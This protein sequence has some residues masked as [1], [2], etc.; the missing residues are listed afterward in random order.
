MCATCA[1][2]VLIDPL[3]KVTSSSMVDGMLGYCH[4]FPSYRHHLQALGTRM[5]IKAWSDDYKEMLREQVQVAPGGA[6]RSPDVIKKPAA[7]Q[8]SVVL[9]TCLLVMIM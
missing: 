4:N 1:L 5:G 9:Q 3:R 8:V 2:Q 7:G 6:G